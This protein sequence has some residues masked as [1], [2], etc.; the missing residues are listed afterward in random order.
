MIVCKRCLRR[1]CV[2]VKW[3]GHNDIYYEWE[4]SCYCETKFEGVETNETTL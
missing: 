2:D 1:K 4:Q 3:D